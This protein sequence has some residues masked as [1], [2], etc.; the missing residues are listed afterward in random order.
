MPFRIHDIR[1]EFTNNS[2]EIPVVDSESPAVTP[3]S[4][5]NFEYGS[6]NPYFEW[7]VSDENPFYY[8][9]MNEFLPVS[10]GPWDGS[11]IN[12]S[13]AGWDLGVYNLT[14]II[15]DAYDQ[16]AMDSVLVT[17]EDTTSP[18]INHPSDLVI[19]P[20]NGSFSILWYP[21]DLL[22]DTY[23]IYQNGSLVE[24]GSWDDTGMSY[25]ISSLE[26]GIYEFELI[27]YD[28]SD[29]SASDTVLVFVEEEEVPSAPL[30]I[31]FII[32]IGG[33]SV[34]VVVVGL[35]CRT[36]GQGASSSSATS[37]DW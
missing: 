5:F 17:I 21:T 12:L 25:N 9:I 15:Q 19:P 20:N 28:T 13:L 37:Y 23:E 7:I 29:N 14:L 24:S 35:I 2:I 36:R 18:L 32:S 22:Y 33:I 3:L 27:V 10:F 31:T 34:I 16:F 4:D 6:D 8:Y 26:V 1:L 11:N 30:D